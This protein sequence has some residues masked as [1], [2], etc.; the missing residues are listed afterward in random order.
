MD[1]SEDPYAR[2]LIDFSDY[3]T[4]YRHIK[5]ERRDNG[6]LE[7]TLHT[8]GGSLRWGAPPRDD[9]MLAFQNAGQDP[10][11]KVI[12]LTG[13]GDDFNGPQ[14]TEEAPITRTA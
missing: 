2:K 12:I 1:K 8:D 4:K 5:M 9:L 10:E 14:A 13:M 11:N 3:G 7:M 6:V